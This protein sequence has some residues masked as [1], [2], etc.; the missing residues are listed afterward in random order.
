VHNNNSSK[1]ES[2]MKNKT[3]LTFLGLAILGFLA[4]SS[5]AG[6]LAGHPNLQAARR[7]INK[8]LAD[9]RRARADE[10]H[11]EFGGHRDKA[12]DLLNQ[13]KA[14]LDAAAEFANTHP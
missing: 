11:G 2:K 10:K 4:V 3:R 12:E 8:A 13:A 14:E 7:S 1:G 6:P 9:C 5:M